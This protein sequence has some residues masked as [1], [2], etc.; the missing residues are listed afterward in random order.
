VP[1]TQR[2]VYPLRGLAPGIG[3][4]T[5]NV[6]GP[7]GFNLVRT[8]ELPVRAAQPVVSERRALRLEAGQGVLVDQNL[9]QDYVATTGRLSLSFSSRPSLDV[10]GLL[11]QLERYPYGCV[12]QTTSTALPLLYF[13]Q[14]AAGWVGAGA[15]QET[16]L[17]SRVQQAIQRI[18]SMQR[19][20]GAF[21]LWHPDS[22]PEVWLT[23][24]ALDFLSRAKAEG[25]LVP[26]VPYQ[27]A[28]EQL[29]KSLL[30]NEFGSVQLASRAYALYVLARVEQAAIGDL[31]YLHDNYLRQLP[32]RLARA[33]LGA[34][35]A[36]YGE[37]N[38]ALEAFQAALEQP[39]AVPAGLRDYGSP[40]RD[41]A[42]LVALL[43]E[44]GLLPEKVPQLAE[45]LAVALNERRYTSTQEQMWL[46]LAA[47]ALLTAPPGQ[48]RLSVN[49]KTVDKEPYF[50]QPTAAQLA[51]GLNI[52]NQGGQPAWYVVNRS[53]VPVQLLP[54]AQQG[55]T[56]TR[57]FY[58]RAGQEVDPAKIRQNDLLVAVISGEATDSESHQALIVDLLAAGLE[59][60]NTR[61]AHASSLADLAWLPKL[62]ATLNEEY[63]DDRYVAALDLDSSQR[64]FNVA[65][66]VRAI[67]PGDYRLP[68][69]FV[70]D[71]YK[72]WLFG[73]AKMGAVKVE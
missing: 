62:S 64:Q 38:R 65:Y 19:S 30:E 8:W 37:R 16:G 42:A 29:Q 40:L 52:A 28:L 36:R 72:P 31:R 12:E 7:G 14:V 1:T 48:L 57:R 3:R 22:A 39:P 11:S 63:R 68:A 45:E 55:F 44:S 26:E 47:R 9:L 32:T 70:E 69:V 51:Q 43:A 34:A 56:I 2:Q 33:Q 66:L 6:T 5:L 23:A 24:Y 21:G 67:T 71:M 41:Q 54:P 27:R 35:L 25:Y 59:I 58:T 49:G 46:L 73:R 53:G 10:P 15:K 13:N 20:D 61:L 18:L 60:E 17:S 50:L 4:V